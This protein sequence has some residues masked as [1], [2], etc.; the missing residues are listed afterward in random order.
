MFLKIDRWLAVLLS[1][2]RPNGASLVAQMVKNPPAMK[3]TQVP[4]LGQ[5]HPLEKNIPVFLAGKSHG[6]RL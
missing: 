6:H 4:A 3:E 1:T 2:P 5:E